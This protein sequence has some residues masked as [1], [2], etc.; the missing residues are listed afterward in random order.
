MIGRICSGYD[1]SAERLFWTDV[2][3]QVPSREPFLSTATTFSCSFATM[4]RKQL[5]KALNGASRSFSTTA[6]ARKV[7]ATN[8]VKAQE[9]PVRPTK[10][11]RH[12]RR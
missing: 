7:V 12:T 4:L 8:P 10:A 9:V 1:G 5:K 3:R 11:R 6:P 2:K